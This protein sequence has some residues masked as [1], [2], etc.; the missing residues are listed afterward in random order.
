MIVALWTHVTCPSCG[1]KIRYFTVATVRI[2]R[3]SLRETGEGGKIGA[4]E[5]WKCPGCREEIPHDRP[6]DSEPY[7]LDEKDTAKVAEY[8]KRRWGIEDSGEAVERVAG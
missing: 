5:D 2:N 4:F 3:R 7:R 8:R 6:L 1:H